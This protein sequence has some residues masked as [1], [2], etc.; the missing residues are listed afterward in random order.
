MLRRCT[1]YAMII[2]TYTYVRMKAVQNL[3]PIR[4]VYVVLRSLGIV[5]YERRVFIVCVDV[6]IW[7][8]NIE[9]P[10]YRTVHDR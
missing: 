6:F 10:E 5:S 4:P 7:K 9:K 3:S 8:K 1:K 2:V